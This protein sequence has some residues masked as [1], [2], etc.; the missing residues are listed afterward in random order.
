MTTIWLVRHGE[1]VSFEDAR[2]D[3]QRYLTETGILTVRRMTQWLADRSPKPD[4]VLHSPLVRA[5]Q[6]AGLWGESFGVTP[7]EDIRLQPGMR[8]SELI[9]IVERYRGGIVVCVGHQPDMSAALAQ[10]I[11]GGRFAFNP[12][13]AARVLAGDIIVPGSASLECLLP[14]VLFM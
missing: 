8:C 6:T 14:P 2:P 10:L 9:D 4:A 1:A 3:E 11:G 12:G 13:T 7:I 5:A